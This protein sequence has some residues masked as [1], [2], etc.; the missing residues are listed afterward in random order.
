VATTIPGERARLGVRHGPRSLSSDIFL[1]GDLLGDVIQHC[2]GPE[3][4]ELEEEARRLG[5]A[6]RAGDEAA[7]EAL[8]ALVSGVS[9]DDAQLLIRSFTKYF[10]LVNLAEDNDRIR[11]I[12]RGEEAA[13]P[14]PRPESI[15]EAIQTLADRGSSHEELQELLD[16]AEVC[17]VLTA[18]PTEARRRTTVE[19]LARV[20]GVIRDLDE[21]H[22]TP[23]DLEIAR[24]R[25]ETTIEELWGSD[26]IRAVSPT[27]LDEVRAGLVYFQSTI[28]RAIPSI[29]RDIEN[30][31]AAAYPGADIRVPPFLFFGS[32]IGGDRDGNPLV[33]ADVTAATLALMRD[34]ALR[35]LE[36]EVQTL[37]ER[38][39]VS[40]RV[41]GDAR[42]L[43]VLL[44]AN[45][46]RFP[47]V[48]AELAER[49]PEEPYRRALT[50]VKER[51]C[52]TREGHHSGYPDPD[53][54][55]AD[56]RLLQ[57]SLR[58]QGGKCMA[59]GD[60]QDVIRLVEVFGFHFA[61]LDV[62]EHAGRHATALAELFALT[63]VE[64]AY[65]ELPDEARFA[66]LAR[67]IANPRPLVPPNLSGLSEHARQV[68]GTF[69][70]VR[71]MLAGGHRG[72]IGSY[73]IS[74]SERPA[75]V[76]EVLL[77]MKEAGLAA[78]GGG[79]AAFRIAPLFESGESLAQAGATLSAL[80][81][82]PS[83]R[84]AL[85]SLGDVQEVMIGYSDSNK[86]GGY[87]ASGWAIHQAQRELSALLDDEGI[88]FTFFHGRGGSIGRGGGPSNVAILS[89]PPGTVDGRIKLTKQGEVVSAKFS[90]REI[91]HREMELM[92]NAVLLST[93]DALPQPA[94]DRL[95]RFEAVAAR[96]AARS[97]D[98]Y[99]DLVYGDQDFVSFF[100][101]A[102]P[103][104]EIAQL[105]LGSR[106]ARRGGS[107]GVEGL[108]A[109]P[110]VFSWTQARIVL[111]GWYGLGTAL[112][113]VRDE[114]GLDELREME[115]DWPFFS[116]LLSNAEM[117]LAKADMRIAERYVALV[118]AAGLRE[119][120]WTPIR[121]EFDTTVEQ[122]LAVTG[123]ERL[124][125]RDPV[126]QRSLDQRN[127]YI[128]PLSFIQ[129]ALL[130]RVRADGDA[131]DLARTVFLAINGV[132]GGL[133]NTG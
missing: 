61:R 115:R 4:F 77:L 73:V 89:Q 99:R 86:E 128:D 97:R 56:L 45:E 14:A 125:D 47:G 96:M 84:R 9:V 5:K 82:E 132:A 15:R 64:P 38:V 44:A 71:D 75:D 34:T 40:S 16:R 68:V 37:A 112:A 36:R 1:L 78:A 85:R 76:L 35:L 11:L 91:A 57:R 109:I 80:I 81:A 59:S 10:Q 121:G 117:A 32:W 95:G 127:P 119:R 69:H 19:K 131:H 67:E 116:A 24:R 22:V 20:F 118:P 25:L 62:R 33:T 17:L 102:T 54:L 2:D 104:E 60:L 65:L 122:V 13:Y 41:A 42:D 50:L 70:A 113:E 8:D 93:L 103:V 43:E 83:Y 58:E 46:A 87:L 49:N 114:I 92:A 28:V 23:R 94:P 120:V 74:H 31:I 66:L 29:Y 101:S 63:G 100:R 18:H 108:R 126:L 133:R 130:R 12:R 129:V 26:E 51:L 72:A 3:A 27:V 123:Q 55:L 98:V 105:R 48:A 88:D 90:T 124:L 21:R 79:D 53:A 107:E 52:A 6:F 110:W 7:G 111:P 30:A 106:P 39:S